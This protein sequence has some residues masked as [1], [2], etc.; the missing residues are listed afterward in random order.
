MVKVNGEHF[1]I[2]GMTI[3]EFLEQSNFDIT[4]IAV[5]MNGEFIPKIR[6]S[7][8]VLKNEDILEVVSFVGGG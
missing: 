4:R 5:E 2:G 3:A 6:Y 7:E 1:D 8:I